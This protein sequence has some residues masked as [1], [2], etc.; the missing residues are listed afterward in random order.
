[1]L[2]EVIKLLELEWGG[3]D[4]AQLDRPTGP[5]WKEKALKTHDGNLIKLSDFPG[6]GIHRS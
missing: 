4:Y 2:S 5:F 1:M 3:V 6:R